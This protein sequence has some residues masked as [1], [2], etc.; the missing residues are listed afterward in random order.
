[1][2]LFDKAYNYT[3]ATEAL[4][5]GWY[6][7]FKPIQSGA[8]AVVTVDGRDMIMIGSNNYLG[9]TQH[10]EV[11]DAGVQA[12]QKYG[13]GCTGS[14][15]LNGT[16]D[17]HEE[18]EVELARYMNKEA[19]LLFSTGFQTNQGFISTIIGKNDLVLSDRANHASIVDGTR[20]AFGKTIKYRHNDM[21]D[22]ER[23]LETDLVREHKGGILLVTD[24]V[25]S[26]EGDLANLPRIVELKKKY[27]F[28]LMVDDAH[29]V[30]V[31]GE[32]GRG[33]AEHFGV[34]DDVDIVMG[35]FSKSFAS[36]GGFIVGEAK[37][38][39]F[40]KHHSRAL[41]FSASMPP[42]NVACVL[43][44]LNI[45]E[46]EPE[47]REQLWKNPRKMHT[48]FTDLGFDIGPTET[49]VVPLL[50]GSDEDTFGFWHTVYEAGIFSNPI[51]TPAVEPGKGLLRT[52]Y[53]A[54][55]TDEILDTVLEICE[56]TGR[57]FGVLGP[58]SE[59]A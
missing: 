52:S 30:G 7:Y 32:H 45:I 1:L 40:I 23:I 58:A 24:G 20:L 21:E 42:S 29:G 38:L 46:R 53:M 6:P 43:A 26:M 18:L 19:C 50:I 2:D 48:G 15:F 27:G 25:F 22:L 4:Q 16:L 56:Q 37:V 39:S 8:G 14:R 34:E 54:T 17:L 13:S 44:A 10:P 28:R 35:T 55:H 36:L 31:M 3:R 11:I 12:M 59:T 57:A 5:E 9:L 33:T 49:P 47:R 41:M 51:I